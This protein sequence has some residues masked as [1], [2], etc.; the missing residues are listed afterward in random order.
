MLLFLY[1]ILCV[2][3]YMCICLHMRGLVA[4]QQQ[5]HIYFFNFLIYCFLWAW[6][7]CF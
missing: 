1:E 7:E 2:G 6:D 5:L 4:E 3:V